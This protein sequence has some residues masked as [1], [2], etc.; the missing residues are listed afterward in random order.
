MKKLYKFRYEILLALLSALFVNSL[1]IRPSTEIGTQI[2]LIGS[3]ILLLLVL[4]VLRKLYRLKWRRAMVSGLQKLMVAISKVFRGL[5]DKWGLS[6]KQQNVITGDTKVF[7]NLSEI[8]R[9]KKKA[10]QKAKSWKHL[11]TQRERLGFLYK[12]SINLRVKH[13]ERIYSSH[14]PEEIKQ[15]AND[16]DC[17]YTLI[18]LYGKYR[19]DERK[20][21][22]GKLVA[23]IKEEL[24]S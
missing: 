10:S 1:I 17:D 20:E 15:N 13:G 24:F 3:V 22:D 18:E 19:Y 21:P 23:S 9:Q 4:L 14:T 11:T 16:S 7:F 2:K 5:L 8:R 6:S 12:K